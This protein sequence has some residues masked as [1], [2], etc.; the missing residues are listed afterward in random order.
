MQEAGSV[1]NTTRSAFKGKPIYF[2]LS[3]FFCSTVQGQTPAPTPTPRAVFPFKIRK[4]TLV[5]KPQNTLPKPAKN[6][7]DSPDSLLTSSEKALAVMDS[8]NDR[9]TELWRYY[10]Q[11]MRLQQVQA[12]SLKKRLDNKSKIVPASQKKKTTRAKIF[13]VPGILNEI[14]GP[15]HQ[16]RIRRVANSLQIPI[17]IRQ[18]SSFLS[19]GKSTHALK[20]AILRF[21]QNTPS[22]Q[23]LILIGHSKGGL[24]LFLTLLTFPDLL[25][26]ASIEKV[27]LIQ[28]PIQGA[29][30]IEDSQESWGFQLLQ[31][32]FPGI[33]ADLHPDNI[34]ECIQDKLKALEP[35]QV[36]MLN[37]KLFYLVGSKEAPSFIIR[38]VFRLIF[39]QKTNAS[40]FLEKS[41][42][43]LKIADQFHP[44]VGQFAGHI[45]ADHWFLY[46]LFFSDWVST[47]SLI[48]MRA[49]FKTIVKFTSPAPLEKDKDS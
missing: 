40:S 34:Q 46:D 3:F 21:A 5:F 33:V 22:A 31:R 36:Q 47:A 13:F 17:V 29:T 38:Y 4:K 48:K 9:F 11:K 49:F 7:C 14:S 20:T 12:S 32:L 27:I 18:N 6:I 37:E 8:P 2:I 26:Q 15:I 28:A 25:Q 43:L 42:G 1:K 39:K 45:H 30:I 41:D 10:E 23:P 35:E 44:A 24:E 16:Q 19:V